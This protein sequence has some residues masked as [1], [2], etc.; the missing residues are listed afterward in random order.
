MNSRRNFRLFLLLTMLAS[1]NPIHQAWPQLLPNSQPF[2]Q[3]PAQLPPSLARPEAIPPPREAQAV[4]TAPRSKGGDSNK[5][6]IANQLST[7][8]LILDLLIR[9][10]T[11]ILCFLLL[12]IGLGLLIFYIRRRAIRQFDL[13]NSFTG[14]FGNISAALRTITNMIWI[15][16]IP[17]SFGFAA[18]VF[19]TNTEVINPIIALAPPS[20]ACIRENSKIAIV[21]IHGWTGDADASWS[22]FSQFACDDPQLKNT[23]IY[24]VIRRI[25]SAE[26]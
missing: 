16:M 22:K 15:T 25:Y 4:P 12:L 17:L 2:P 24:G 20:S 1:I 10:Q 18:F 5:G 21:L 3:P 7:A 26:I 23:D 14:E 9:N 8:D 6:E 13:V 11:S 19:F